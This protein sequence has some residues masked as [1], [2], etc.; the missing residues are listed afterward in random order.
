M[1]QRFRFLLGFFLIV[2]GIVLL[3][4]TAFY[5]EISYFVTPSQLMKQK[6]M[7]TVRLGGIVRS[8]R[9]EGTVHRF[10]IHDDATEIDVTFQGALP[11]LFKEGQNVI[12]E[13]KQNAN[14]TFNAD[15]VFAKHDE[16]Y[17]PKP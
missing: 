3:A 11:P 17:C 1:T 15:Q 9:R 12:I 2:S 7:G 13:G 5:N 6:I 4:V 8:Y 10:L 16:T 14:G